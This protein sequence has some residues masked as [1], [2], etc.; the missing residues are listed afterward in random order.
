M[1]ALKG[2]LIRK[3]KIDNSFDTQCEWSEREE[4]GRGR[5]R[6]RASRARDAMI[7]VIGGYGSSR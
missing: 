4:C 1:G 3:C 5:V 6:C 2:P 7:K